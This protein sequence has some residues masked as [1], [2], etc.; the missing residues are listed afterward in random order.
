MPATAYTAQE[1]PSNRTCRRWY[2]IQGNAVILASIRSEQRGCS[3]PGNYMVR[4]TGECSHRGNYTVGIQGNAV[5]RQLYVG[6]T[7]EC[8]HP[9]NYTLGIQGGAPWA[10]ARAP[11]PTSRKRRYTLLETRITVKTL[12]SLI[13]SEKHLEKLVRFA[14][15]SLKT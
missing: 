6:N 5:I 2:N 14:Y 15:K 3:H 9:G 10:G 11:A 8:S 4:N 7:G 13:F 1:C 12:E